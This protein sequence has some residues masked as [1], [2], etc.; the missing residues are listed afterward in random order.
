M[1]VA[2][3]LALV[4]ASKPGSDL[5]T[6]AA[7]R[8]EKAVLNKQKV[9]VE[10]D[11]NGVALVDSEEEGIDMDDYV[12]TES[13]CSPKKMLT[14]LE[15][16]LAFHAWYKRGH[17]FSL[18]TE[19]EKT[20]MLRAIRIMLHEIKVN[21]PREDKNGWKLQKFHDMLHI[22]SDIENFGSPNNVDAAPNENNLI[23][24]AK[25]PGK[26]AHKKNKFLFYKS[27]RLRESDLIR[28]AYH[29]LL[30]SM[31]NK[32]C[33]FEES[34]DIVMMDVDSTNEEEEMVEGVIESRLI[35]NPFVSC[36]SRSTIQ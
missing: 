24:F 17:P 27:K 14:M 28:K 26:R 11:E 34:E 35:G 20:A 31:D 36:E 9:N 2:F 4:A 19:K 32:N 33:S 30:R 3:V 25:R 13:L 12:Y 16:I 21:A 7:T 1:R 22:V 6:K 5:F 10:L 8:I 15:M 23:D 18:K 29:A